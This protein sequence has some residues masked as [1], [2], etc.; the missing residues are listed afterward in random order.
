MAT[1]ARRLVVQ[2][3]RARHDYFI[4]DRLEVGLALIGSE[5]KSLRAGKAS[6]A[7]AYAGEEGGELYLLNAHIA[8]YAPANRFGHEPRRPRK[9]LVH[10]RERDRLLGLIRREGYTLVPLAVYFNDRGIAK[11][12][13][14]LARGKHKHDKREDVKQRDWQR[15]KARLMREHG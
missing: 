2:N 1:G 11:L 13:L 14:G 12:D 15:Q 10:R 3:R 8:E 5:V 7:E 9:L 4:E 6:L